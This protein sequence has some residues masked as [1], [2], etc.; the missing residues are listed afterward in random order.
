[1]SLS[2]IITYPLPNVPSLFSERKW[3]APKRS[4]FPCSLG[5]GV[6]VA[7]ILDVVSDTIMITYIFWVY[8]KIVIRTHGAMEWTGPDSDRRPSARQADVLTRLDDRSTLCIFFYVVFL[9]RRFVFEGVCNT[10]FSSLY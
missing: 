7:V 9:Y 10:S 1:M 6:Y 5:Q 8:H 3:R 2:K 4:F